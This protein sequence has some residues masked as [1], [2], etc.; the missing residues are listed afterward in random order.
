MAPRGA[1]RPDVRLQLLKCSNLSF[2]LR[3]KIQTSDLANRDHQT[4]IKLDL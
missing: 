4:K 2:K 3:A 1:I